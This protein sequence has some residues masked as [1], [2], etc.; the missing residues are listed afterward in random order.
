MPIAAGKDKLRWPP[1]DRSVDAIPI[2]YRSQA[3][4]TVAHASLTSARSSTRAGIG[5]LQASDGTPQTGLA[6]PVLSDTG[7]E[8]AGGGA[9][10]LLLAGFDRL[11]SAGRIERSVAC[12]RSPCALPAQRE[13][14]A[15]GEETPVGAATE[16]SAGA[17]GHQRFRIVTAVL[18]DEIA[19][20]SPDAVRG[21]KRLFDESW[22]GSRDE[23]LRLEADIQLGLLGT[24]N[25]LEAVRAGML[26]EPA[27]FV[28]PS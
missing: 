20:R 23:T 6:W 22:T 18:A 26:K 15:S 3:G 14:V 7:S 21:M 27:Q 17:A 5:E 24:P 12:S 19:G 25:Q 9:A 13:A 28:D 2:E 1:E 10:A 8:T 16:V 4:R 11:A